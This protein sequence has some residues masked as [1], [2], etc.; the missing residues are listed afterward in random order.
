MALHKAGRLEKKPD[1]SWFTTGLRF[2]K[3]RRQEEWLR[4]YPSNT[5]KYT[6]KYLQEAFKKAFKYG[7]F[8][9]FKSKFRDTPSFTI[10]QDVSIKNNRILIPKV[11]YMKIVRKGPDK[12][13]HGEAKRATVKLVGD[14]WFVAIM[15]ELPEPTIKDNG[16]AIGIDMNVGQIATSEGTIIQMP[17]T[18]SHELFRTKQE[19]GYYPHKLGRRRPRRSLG[20][21]WKT[22]PE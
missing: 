19:K 2:T 15:Y 14:K 4:K 8:P 11:G 20:H 10:P 12:Y 13:R 6:L 16:L 9:K 5:V 17:D 1:I 21:S 7:G 22:D 3:L 18:K